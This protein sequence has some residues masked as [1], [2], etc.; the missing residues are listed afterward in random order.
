MQTVTGKSKAPALGQ[1][2]VWVLLTVQT[3]RKQL[4]AANAND[5]NGHGNIQSPGTRANRCLGTANGQTERKHPF[6]ASANDANGHGETQAPALGQ[7]NVCVL[8][9]IQTFTKISLL[10]KTGPHLNNTKTNCS[11]GMFTIPETM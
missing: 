1:I 10:W 3:V 9:A 2:D 7:R 6:A 5:A 4:L 11:H 8:L